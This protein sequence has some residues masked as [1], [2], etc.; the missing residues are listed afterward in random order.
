MI[1]FFCCMLMPGFY[2][3]WPLYHK[4]SWSGLHVADQLQ[5]AWLV[6]HHWKVAGHHIWVSLG[7]FFIGFDNSLRSLSYIVAVSFIGVGNRKKNQWS[8]A[9]HWQTLS[10]NVHLPHKGLSGIRAHV[11]VPSTHILHPAVLARYS[12]K[13]FDC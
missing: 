11:S 8:A 13:K 12:K 3:H 2:A 4:C 6:H 7:F 9:S 10:H 1:L 5:T